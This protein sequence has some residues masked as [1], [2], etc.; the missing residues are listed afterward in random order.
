MRRMRG[1]LIVLII[2]LTP[3]VFIAAETIAECAPAHKKEPVWIPMEATAYCSGEITADGSRVREGI[4]AAK[5]EWI[6]MTAAVYLDS[7]AE[8]GV[9][10]P[11]VFLG[12]YEIKD[13]GGNE[14]IQNGQAIDIYNPSL[15]WCLDFGRKN[16]WVVLTKGEG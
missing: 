11:G 15:E 4:C 13:T 1:L 7:V 6:G 10:G 5:K 14:L 16:V 12:Y 9:H 3:A 8:D 2:C